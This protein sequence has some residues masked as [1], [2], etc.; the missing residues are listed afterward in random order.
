MQ[1]EEIIK[2]DIIN[3]EALDLTYLE[4]E[5]K[6]YSQNTYGCFLKSFEIKDGIKYYYK[7]SNYD[8]YR[9]VFGY[10]SINEYIVSRLLDVLKIEHLKYD[11]VYARIRVDNKEF[12]T[13]I[14]VSE[15]FKSI[16]E[17]KEP[18]D[19]YYYVNR[20]DNESPIDFIIRLGFKEYLY[21]M[22]FVDYVIFNRDRHG[23]N[24]EI[25]ISEN[26]SIRLSPFFDHGLSL[27]LSD[28]N[29]EIYVNAY[30]IF[31][32]EPT[33]SFFGIIS[34]YENLKFIENKN[35]ID[36]YTLTFNDFEY[37]FKNLNSIIPKYTIDKI[38]KFISERLKIWQN[39]Q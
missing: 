25:L 19:N 4:F 24:V 34:T 11:L 28:Y 30:D 5:S 35:I 16:N 1:I 27:L 15:E 20:I 31:K 18:F 22:F 33:N 36:N 9:N 7:V 29:N 26:G 38:I 23:A 37:I 3:C 2:N 32:S 10:E 6:S 14:S 39:F 17:R 13:Y 21:K 8:M 12:N